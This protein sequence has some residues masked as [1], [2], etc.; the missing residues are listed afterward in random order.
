MGKIEIC[1]TVHGV[2][3]PYIYTEYHSNLL[4]GLTECGIQIFRWADVST[5]MY[6]SHIIHSLYVVSEMSAEKS[7]SK[8]M[9]FK[10]NISSPH[11]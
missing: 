2:D 4:H 7:R 5:N 11:K 9:F 1:V 10:N 8:I 6:D 3:H